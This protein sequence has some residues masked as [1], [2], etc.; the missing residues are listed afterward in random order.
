MSVAPEQR[1][2]VPFDSKTHNRANF[3]CGRPELDRY[4]REIASQ[5]TKRDLARVFVALDGADVVGFYSLSGF[6]FDRDDLPA[7]HAKNLPNYVIPAILLGRLAVDG[8]WAGQ[9]LGLGMLM[10]ALDRILHISESAGFYSIIVDAKDERT[11]EFYLKY[12]FIRFPNI[13]N[14]LFLLMASVRAF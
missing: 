5:D 14:R 2:I 11:A 6:G 7:S 3:S 8:A 10:D 4:I 9:G 12:G 13:P 1:Q